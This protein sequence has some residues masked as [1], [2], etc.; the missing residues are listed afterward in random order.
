[1]LRLVGLAMLFLVAIAARGQA[2]DIGHAVD[3]RPVAAHQGATTAAVRA[4]MRE[5]TGPVQVTRVL[6]A[7]QPALRAGSPAGFRREVV[8][9]TARSVLLRPQ[10]RQR[11]PS[12]A[13]SWLSH[14]RSG[15]ALPLTDGVLVGLGYRHMEG[16][17]LWP[18][19]ADTGAVGYD[20]H[21]L[22]VRAHWRF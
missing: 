12:T 20:S 7:A 15:V 1:M 2:K 6:P 19:F 11:Q 3:G 21:H 22:L 17:D 13:F 8:D 18:E 4:A 9:Q 5:R 16:E 10:R 14:G